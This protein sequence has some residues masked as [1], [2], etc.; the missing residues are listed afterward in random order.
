M[1]QHRAALQ[2][3]RSLTF[4]IASGAAAASNLPKVAAGPAPLA[5]PLATETAIEMPYRLII[6]PNQYGAWAHASTP[7]SSQAGR[8]ELWHTRLGSRP[9]RAARSTR[10]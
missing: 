9:A 4:K 6:S 8:T 7:V 10:P 1:V 5:P 3:G 2:A